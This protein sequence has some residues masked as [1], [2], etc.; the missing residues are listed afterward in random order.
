MAY[1]LKS[2]LNKVDKEIKDKCKVV[3]KVKEINVGDIP[4]ELYIIDKSM[5]KKLEL[6]GGEDDESTDN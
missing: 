3:N 4:V 1:I 5:T 6:F 2:D